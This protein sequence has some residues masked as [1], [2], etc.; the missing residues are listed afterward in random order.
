V[1]PFDDITPENMTYEEAKYWL[2][3]WILHGA[4]AERHHWMY[5]ESERIGNLCS[6]AYELLGDEKYSKIYKE[7]VEAHT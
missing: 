5:E 4:I 6:K 2:G 3:S 7:V 1:K